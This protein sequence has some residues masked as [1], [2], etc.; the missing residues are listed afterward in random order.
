M[1]T[2][3][4]LGAASARSAMVAPGPADS[5]ETAASDTTSAFCGDY[6]KR[7][8][9]IVR[10]RRGELDALAGARVFERE[11]GRVQPLSRQAEALGE[12]RVGTVGQVADAGVMEC[13]HVH[14]DLVGAAGFQLDLQQSRVPERLDRVVMGDRVLAVSGDRPLVVQLGVAADRCVYR[15]AHRVRVPLYERVVSLVH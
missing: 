14:P 10:V 2:S 12:R 15:A 9:K 7:V 1:S 11:P 3:Q 13:G 5:S 8:L 6:V 4:P